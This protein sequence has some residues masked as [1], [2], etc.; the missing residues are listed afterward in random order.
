MSE[1]RDETRLGARLG[2]LWRRPIFGRLEQP[3]KF[4]L[5]QAG[6][7][8]ALSFSHRDRLPRSAAITGL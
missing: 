7:A 2:Y 3:A 4:E 5:A 1:E 8:L 6:G